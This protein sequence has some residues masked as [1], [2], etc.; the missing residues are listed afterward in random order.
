MKYR[1][2][3][4]VTP[5]RKAS[6]AISA[7]TENIGLGGVCLLLEKGLEIFS[8]VQLELDLKDSGHPLRLEGTVVWVV[9]RR[10]FRKGA[11]YDTGVEFSELSPQDRSR[12]E[13]VVDRA[14]SKA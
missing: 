13:A 10:E 7:V 9:R 2:V 14:G 4:R 6:S 8:P 5:E 12:I 11:T 3:V 1:C